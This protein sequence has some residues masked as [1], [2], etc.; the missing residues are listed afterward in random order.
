MTTKLTQSNPII[1]II[2]IGDEILIG[3][4]VDTNSAWMARELNKEGFRISQITTVPDN[5]SPILKAIDQAFGRADI[6]LMTGGLGPTKDDITKQTLCKYY[7]TK[8]VFNPEV[9]ETIQEMFVNRPQVLNELTLAQANVPEAATVIQNKRGTAPVTWFEKKDKVLVSMPGVPSEMEWVMSN[10]VLPRLRTRFNTPSLLHKTVL[11]IGIPESNLALQLTEW[12]DNLPECIRLA[13][14][15]SP[16]MV[17]LRMSG[18]LPDS[19][20]LASIVDTELVKLREILGRSIFAEEDAPPEEVVGRLLRKHGLW[21]ATAES[22]TGGNVAHKLTSVSG[23][24]EYFIGSVVAYKNE[25]KTQLLGV[26]MDTLRNYGSVSREVVEEMAEGVRKGL[27]ADIGV[28]VTGIAGPLGATEGK[29]VG[30]VWVGVCNADKNISRRFQFG[31]YRKR[32]I[33]MATL[34]AFTLIKELLEE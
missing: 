26:S 9:A 17:R 12:E 22:C 5:E 31:Q 4:V 2:T 15:P 23:S 7:N 29:P 1:E 25:V 19:K 13:Y 8:L 21:V 27:N 10:E 30:T 16:G 24:S 18:F 20:K 33:E 14:L 6:V 28:A 11:V 32:N 3:Q 34:A